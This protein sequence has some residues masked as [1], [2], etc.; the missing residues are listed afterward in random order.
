MEAL[1]WLLIPSEH[2]LAEDWHF[3]VHD[4][5]KAP[6]SDLSGTRDHTLPREINAAIH[7]AVLL[8]S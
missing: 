6:I 1:A 3:V 7:L 2:G 5:L 8:P 4:W